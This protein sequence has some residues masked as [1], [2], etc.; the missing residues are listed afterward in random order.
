M[1]AG[2]LSES[3]RSAASERLVQVARSPGTLPTVRHL[4]P[5]LW[6]MLLAGCSGGGG[7]SG[8]GTPPPTV[9]LSAAPTSIVAG[10]TTRLT[11]SATGATSCEGTGGWLGTLPT[12]GQM[13][14]Q[15]PGTSTYNLVC[16]GRGGTSHASVGVEVAPALSRVSGALLVPADA[17]TDSDTNTALAA[18]VANNAFAEAQQLPNPV[19]LGGYV[20]AAGSG[21]AGPL[22]DPGDLEDYF[23]V[24]LLAGQV[25]ELVAANALADVNDLD[26]ELYGA[27]HQL[28]DGSYGSGPVERLVAKAS[29]DHYVRVLAA[30]GASIYALSVGRTG[31]T[32]ATAPTLGGAFVPGELL[33]RT[34]ARAGTPQGAAKLAADTARRH[35]LKPLAGAADRAWLTGIT[36]DTLHELRAEQQLHR[37]AAEPERFLSDEQRLKWA[38]LQAVKRVAADADVA[39][40]EP[41]WLV[42]RTAVPNDPLYPR[43]RWHYELLQLPAAWDITTGS[44]DVTVAIVDT[45]IR[46]HPDL[47]GQ[48]RGGYDFVRSFSNGDGDGLD[49]DPSDPGERVKGSYVFHGTHVAGT[50]AAATNDGAGAAGIAWRVRLMPVRVVGTDGIGSL[51]DLVQGV[52]YAA[53]LPN[54]SGTVPPARA[55]VINVSISASAP[56]PA[57]LAEAVSAARAAGSIF[58]AAVGNQNKDTEHFPSGCAGVVGVAAVDALSQ[59]AP[60]SN[61]GT[62]V[63]V[64][65]PGGHLG[66]DRDADGYG[67]GVFSTHA[68]Y[69]GRTYFPSHE[70]LEGT[71]MAAP[72]V[73]GVAALMRSVNPSLTPAAFDALLDSGALTVDIGAPGR[74]AL[75]VGLINALAAVRAAGGQPPSRPGQLT[76]PQGTLN[77][78]AS[79]AEFDLAVGN[80]GTEPVRVTAV[81][82]SDTWLSATASQVDADGLGRYRLTVDRSGLAE[83]TY[84]GWV[85]FA[86]SAGT[87]ARTSVQMQ[88]PPAAAKADAGPHY[89][90]LVDED[91][92]RNAYVLNVR[93][94]GEKVDFAFAN[95]AA[96]RYRLIAGTD[97]DGN[98]EICEGGEA[99]GRYPVYSNDMVLT[100]TGD[101]AGLDFS[102]ELRPAAGQ[103]AS[104]ASAT[105]AE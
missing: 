30:R 23:R 73:S 78:G 65:A 84:G 97:L 20:N 31:T 39:W 60:Y 10:A 66:T 41:N 33:I 89:L 83:G 55:D 15:P 99:C 22:R 1:E 105:A 72:H 45:G 16:S 69:D 28:L 42:F 12:S 94:R 61:Y 43:Q 104:P 90:M 96:G 79:L 49:A 2:I 26:L 54:D 58:V 48:R 37:A 57:S 62:G 87:A 98:G 52:L 5:Y 71:S 4:H 70:Y 56:C 95:V 100:I 53:G 50:V 75:G 76:V 91:T 8:G 35:A 11:W 68:R 92:G 17:R 59:K 74:D 102:T 29:G 40:A 9:S 82:V 44:A 7:G 103:A 80:A 47:D 14:L 63:D 13:D 46:S 27:G 51:S 34:V 18:P 101:L 38:T 32:S 3:R 6:A 25:I 81:R 85:E 93:A 88:V 21:P 77:F 64:A 86:G 36:P 67:D 24:S 19:L